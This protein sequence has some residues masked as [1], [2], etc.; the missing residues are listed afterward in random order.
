[1]LRKSQ[2]AVTWLQT[3]KRACVWP[4]RL[5]ELRTGTR[6]ARRAPGPHLS[7]T[8]LCPWLVLESLL[9][10]LSHG[11]SPQDPSFCALLRSITWTDVALFGEISPFLSRLSPSVA[12]PLG[13]NYTVNSVVSITPISHHQPFTL[14]SVM[15]FNPK[16]LG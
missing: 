4:E 5:S 14:Y 13:W 1:M 2:S 3:S 12:R 6:P 7:E 10:A 11:P 16:A 15:L 8:S 9:P